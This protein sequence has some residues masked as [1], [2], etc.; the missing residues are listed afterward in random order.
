MTH[1][2]RI[3][4]FILKFRKLTFIQILQQAML[5]LFPVVLVGSFADII[6]NNLLSA[7]G[8]LGSMLH[9]SRVPQYQFFR[10]IFNDLTI[11]TTGWIST[12]AAMASAYLTT[13]HFHKTSLL[14]GIMGG[15]TYVLIFFH[16]V[17]GNNS[18]IEMRYYGA[19]WFIIG[20]TVG[21]LVGRVFAKYGQGLWQE[22]NQTRAD[23][24]RTVFKNLKPVLIVVIIGL[25]IHSLYGLYRQFNLDS[26]VT[27]N[28]TSVLNRHSNYL[29]NIL[30]SLITTVSIWLGF[31]A[32]LDFSSRIFDNE[33]FANLNFALTHKTNWGIPYPFTP[34][35]L[36]NG[37]AQFGGVGVSLALLLA[38]LWVG[39]KKDQQQVAKLTA[40]PVFFNTPGSLAFGIGLP[41][42]PV[43]LIPFVLLPIFNMVVASVVIYLHLIPT[44]VYPV[45]TGTPGILTA[46][47][48]SGG[49]LMALFFSLLLLLIDTIIYIPFVKYANKIDEQLLIEE[50]ERNHE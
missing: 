15:V 14:S 11:V 8:Y 21:Y 39:Y 17:H 47:V 29:L 38:I 3:N 45:A 19:G 36:Y 33:V 4:N 43:Y 28:L 10:A 18:I 34:S 49:N 30:I 23:I 46:F 50:G 31:T 7:Q 40:I 42:N 44:I 25:V 41:L 2:Q 37:F 48:G 20:I 1:Q 26:I 32:P 24:L 9:I 6:S 13:R 35:A 27:Q 22:R 5:L 12:Y 16:S